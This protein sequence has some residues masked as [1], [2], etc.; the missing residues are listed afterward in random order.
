[1]ENYTFLQTSPFVLH[2]PFY[3]HIDFKI[4]SYDPLYLYGISC[5]FSAFISDFIVLGLCLIFSRWIWLNMYQLCLSFQNFALNFIDYILF[6]HLFLLR[7]FYLFSSTNFGFWFSFSCSFW[8][9]QAIY[10]FIYFSL[11]L[12]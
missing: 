10:L 12:R 3:W 6:F 1:M 8:C 11:L 9:S 7:F 2:C 4:I 5:T